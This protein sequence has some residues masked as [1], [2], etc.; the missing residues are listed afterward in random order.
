M[1]KNEDQKIS[2]I[3]GKIIKQEAY[4]QLSIVIPVYNG[5]EYIDHLFS[6]IKNQNFKKLEVIF[7]DDGSAD[8]SSEKIRKKIDEFRDDNQN[9]DSVV[10]LITEENK[11]QG[12]ARNTGIEAASGKWLMFID[13]DDRLADGY[14]AKMYQKA[15]NTKCDILISGYQREQTDGRLKEKVSLQNTSWSKYMNIT[16]W[17]KIF[18]TSFLKDKKVQFYQTPLGE[19]IYFSLLAYSSTDQICISSYVGYVWVNNRKSVSN[20]T[21][22]VLDPSA[23]MLTL[24]Q[25]M[26]RSIPGLNFNDPEI[27]YFLLKTAVFHILDVAPSADYQDVIRYKKDLFQFLD[28]NCHNF[29]KNNLIRINRPKGERWQIRFVLYI[30]MKLDQIGLS[31]TFLKIFQQIW[32]VK[33]S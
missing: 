21:H 20:T 13:Q 30:F 11:G 25:K 27:E 14:F 22:K 9:M 6:E 33:E 2:N 8:D 5:N 23:S 29:R 17:G 26:H 1:N 28:E 3:N 15:E 10:R 19:D 16:P 4:F 32:K 18:R 7:V 31:D 24:F 12:G